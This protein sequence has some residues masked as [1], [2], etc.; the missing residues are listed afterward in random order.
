MHW[1]ATRLSGVN[2]RKTFFRVFVLMGLLTGVAGIVLTGYVA[3]GTIGGGTGYELSAIASCVIGGTSLLG[4]E[5]TI[6]GALVGSLIMASLENGM[7]VMNMNIFWQYI[8]KGLVLIFAVYMDI[9]SKKM[10]S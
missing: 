5:G 10:K 8:I 1:E 6:I 2:I 7:S 4:G 9:A 3:A